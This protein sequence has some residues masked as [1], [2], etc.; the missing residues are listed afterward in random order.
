MGAHRPGGHCRRLSSLSG[1]HPARGTG[2][3]LG[4]GP[5]GCCVDST[6]RRAGEGQGSARGHCTSAEQSRGC[7]RAELG[8]RGWRPGTAL[9]TLR[10]GV[11]T[12]PGGGPQLAQP[13]SARSKRSALGSPQEGSTVWELRARGRTGASR[14]LLALAGSAGLEPGSAWRAPFPTHPRFAR[15]ALRGAAQPATARPWRQRAVTAPRA[16][17]TGFRSGPRPCPGK[18]LRT[19][20]AHRPRRPER[21]QGGRVVV[22]NSDKTWVTGRGNGNPLQSS[23]LEGPMKGVKSEG[24]TLEGGT[25]RSEGVQ[26]ATGEGRGQVAQL[27]E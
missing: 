7:P 14:R 17:L 25:P 23:C 3:D 18:G 16:R 6:Q 15:R 12:A 27:K 22:K 21:H 9:R 4:S 26:D 13:R 24:V 8:T 10:A 20:G 5:S 11:G 1:F 2:W 19:A